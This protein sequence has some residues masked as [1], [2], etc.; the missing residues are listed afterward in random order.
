MP[1]LSTTSGSST[2]RTTRVRLLAWASLEARLLHHEQPIQDL[3]KVLP[4][5]E[6][7][8]PALPEPV[9]PKGLEV[10]LV[11]KPSAD[12]TA[13]SLGFPLDITRA[14]DDFYALAVANSYL[15]EHRTFNGKLMQDLRGKRGLNY[16]DYSYIE[17]FIQDGFGTFPVPNNP[18]RQQAFSIWIRPVPHDKAPF[19]LRAALWELDRLVEDGMTSDEFEATRE[20]LLNYSKLW[21]Q[22]LDRRLGYDMEG[23]FYG[24]K[25]LVDELAERLPKLTVEQVNAAVRKHLK[26]DGLRV[27]IV[28]NDAKALADLLK[29]NQPTPLVYDTEG[30]PD[31]VLAEDKEIEKFPLLDVSTTDHPGRPDVR[32]VTGFSENPEG[33]STLPRPRALF[34]SATARPPHPAQVPS[35][36]LPRSRQAHHLAS[37]STGCNSPL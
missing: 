23:D 16:G 2:R 19:A 31:E 30:T 8:P 12:A 25:S 36:A 15:G 10:T 1:S 7:T 32:K 35:L 11:E 3:L 24:R 18:R 28:T 20:F 27:A 22:T 34:S 4:E 13:I 5:M 17:D 14:D 33:E 37:R 26:S 9:P 6:V 21:V 29:S